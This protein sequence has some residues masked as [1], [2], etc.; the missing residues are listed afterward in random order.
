M[1]SLPVI[2]Y[3]ERYLKKRYLQKGRGVT[4]ATDPAT[5]CNTRSFEC[6]MNLF[7]KLTTFRERYE[8]EGYKS[9]RIRCG[10]AFGIA[11]GVWNASNAGHLKKC[12][13]K[14]LH[15]ICKKK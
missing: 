15:N 1:D 7:V 9:F 13:K 11:R 12:V 4:R 6:P 3:T 8:G 10:G 14:I 5:A 2:P